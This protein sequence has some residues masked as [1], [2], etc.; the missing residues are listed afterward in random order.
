[1]S[2]SK[3]SGM[4]SPSRAGGVLL[5]SLGSNPNCSSCSL[6]MPSPSRSGSL[7]SPMP[8]PS[9]SDHSEGSEGKRSFSLSTPSPSRSGSRA[10]GMPSPSRSG[11]VLLGSLGSNP[12]CSSYS[13]LMPSPSRSGSLL[14]PIPSPS[15]SEE[16]TSELQSRENL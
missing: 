1:M 14:S 7:L 5:G 2:S 10:S 4:P 12:N 8:S 3:A 9:R 11:G 6:L 13:L 16:H 15:R